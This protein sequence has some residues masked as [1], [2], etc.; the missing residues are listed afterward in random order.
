MAMSLELSRISAL[1]FDVDGTLRD[2]DD[3]MVLTLEKW[4]RIG[5]FF[6]PGREPRSLARWLVMKTETPGNF[7]F[8][9]P[10]RLG[11]DERLARLGNLLRRAGLRRST[12]TFLIIQ[13]VR[14]MLA[15]LQ[16]YY[17][18]SVVSARDKR[19]TM[20][21]LDQFDL[22]P[23]FQYVA[24]AHTCR[25]TKPYPDPL[26][27]VAERMG[28]PIEN[29]L[30]IG[31]TTVDIRAGIAA[32]AQTVGVL[33]G[34]GEQCELERIGADLILANTPALAEVLLKNEVNI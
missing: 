24:T 3:Q 33:C 17:P 30:M 19:T 29:C 11:I 32:G 12:N 28:V 21:F 4:L 2:T 27:W 34:F 7:V 16:P 13:G 23:F 9:L 8:G 25:Y 31:D 15:R 22:T 5:S 20:A 1:I 26:L 10:D 14:E 18:M 6:F